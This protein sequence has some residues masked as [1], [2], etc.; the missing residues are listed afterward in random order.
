[1]TSPFS[2]LDLGEREPATFSLVTGQ[3]ADDEVPIEDLVERLEEQVA[4]RLLTNAAESHEDVLRAARQAWACHVGVHVEFVRGGSRVED[5]H[6]G[7]V[8]PIGQGHMETWWV[9]C[10]I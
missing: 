2:G 8:Q 4:R 9:L 1:M 3:R 5:G 10:G 7:Q 6:D